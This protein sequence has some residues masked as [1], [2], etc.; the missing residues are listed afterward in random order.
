MIKPFTFHK[1]VTGHSHLIKN[2]PIPCEDFSSSYSAPDGRYHIC[3]VS[4]GHGDKSCF[5][6]S[7]GS[8]AVVEATLKALKGFADGLLSDDKAFDTFRHSSIEQKRKIKNL[9]DCIVNSWQTDIMNEYSTNPPTAEELAGV[10]ADVL[11]KYERGEHLAHV[12]G[13]TL[14]AGILIDGKCLILLQQG[15]GRCNVFYEDG[16]CDQPVPWDDRCYENVTTSMC[17]TDAASSVRHCVIDTSKKGVIACFVGSDGVED[18]FG[19]SASTMAGNYIFYK[20]LSCEVLDRFGNSADLEGYMQEDFTNL[21]KTGSADDVS[22]SGIIDLEGVKPFYES[23]KNEHT[24][25]SLNNSYLFYKKKI[26]SM[27]MKHDYYIAE[28][29]KREDAISSKKNNVH[30]IQKRIRSLEAE[31]N[32]LLMKKNKAQQDYDKSNADAKEAINQT[33]QYAELFMQYSQ[34]DQQSDDIFSHSSDASQHTN[35]F[36]GEIASL[37]KQALT[38][39]SG[40]ANGIKSKVSSSYSVYQRICAKLAETEESIQRNTRGLADFQRNIKK[41]EED[42]EAL[43]QERDNYV[44]LYEEF[45]SKRDEIAAQ[46][47]SLGGTLPS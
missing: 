42:L 24:A 15:D 28:V 27:Q 8:K 3:V 7:Y 16:T 17:D 22:V 25:Y 31:R 2:P 18:S 11:K 38:L 43:K 47:K 46:I 39:I 33:Q 41:D 26:E 45:V 19:D 10:R 21:S 32:E 35:I 5:R 23:F 6:S 36:S 30:K 1:T 37:H 29:Q 4:D 9:T 13:A 34:G 20:K 44:A 12:Y 14:L 40:I